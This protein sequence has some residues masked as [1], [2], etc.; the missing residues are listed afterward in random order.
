[1]K[2][3]LLDETIMHSFIIRIWLEEKAEETGTA[4]WRG[5]IT[6]IPSNQRRHIENLDAVKQFINPYLQSMGV[7][8][9][10]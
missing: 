4:T 6:H 2:M 3:E 5:H 1:M 8:I 7:R 9:N 10:K